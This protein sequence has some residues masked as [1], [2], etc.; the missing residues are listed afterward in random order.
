MIHTAEFDSLCYLQ[1]AGEEMKRRRVERGL[2]RNEL[3]RLACVHVNTIGSIERGEHDINSTTKCWILAALGTKSLIMEIHCDHIELA[4]ERDLFPRTDIQSRPDAEVV[5]IIGNAIRIQ[6]E[7]LGLSLS[8][9][10]LNSGIHS[11]TLWNIERG[12]VSSTGINLHCIYLALG[13]R[14]ATPS[15]FM[16]EFEYANPLRLA[17][18]NN[19]ER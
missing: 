11:N 9:L 15:A 5:R 2:T 17:F 19:K 14:K 12:L 8:E 16:L 18:G 7:G 4:P 3:A 10:A 6:R 13:I 1:R